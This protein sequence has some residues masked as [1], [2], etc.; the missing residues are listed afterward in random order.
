MRRSERLFAI[1]EHLRG[2]RSGVTAGAL[3]E[4]FGVT[5]RTM[6]RDLESLKTAELPLVAERGRGGGFALERDYS[7]PPV[8]FTAREAAV[9]ISAA[10]FLA[11]M[12]VLPFAE[13]LAAGCDKLRAALSRSAQREFLARLDELQFVGVP[14]KP[15]LLAVRT[16]LEQAWLH[17]RPLWVRYAG[18]RGESERRVRL[19]QI[20]MERGETLL[21]VEDLEIGEARQ[22]RL[23]R[24]LAAKVLPAS[25]E[26]PAEPE[27]KRQRAR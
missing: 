24:V 14:A 20:V 21:N 2:R 18:S 4:R 22:L 3:A 25:G 23:D 12:R 5:L 19:R 17:Q 6:Y 16:A 9:L 27:P 10:R 1:A 8:N 15:T 26:L 13:T 7:M 11:A